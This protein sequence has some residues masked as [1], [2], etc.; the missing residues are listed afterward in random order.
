MESTGNPAFTL[1]FANIA[2]IDENDIV[3]A[4][5]R[6]GL[7]DGQGLDRPLRRLDQR[8]MAGDN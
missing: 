5:Q 4:V 7:L 8:S 6:Q 2:D 1:E 3:A